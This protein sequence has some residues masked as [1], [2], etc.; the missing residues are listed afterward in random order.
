[1]SEAVFRIGAGQGAVDVGISAQLFLIA[2]PCVIESEGHCV[3]IAERL[4]DIGRR[5]GVGVLFKASFDKAN[6]SSIS[7]FRG[8]GLEA[9][10]EILAR[11]REKSGLPVVTDVH[12][13]AQAEAVAKVADCLQVPAF[14]CRQT[15]LLCACARTAKPVNVKKGQFVSPA[16]M[17]NVV[18]KINACGNEKILLTERGTFFGYNRLVNDMTA[19]EGMKQLGY[20]VVFDATHSTQCPGGLGNASAGNPEMS[21][22][23][24]KAAIAAGANGL[25]L[26]VHTD[27]KK[28]KSDA[29]CVVP[30]E[31]VEPLLRVSR[32]IFEIVR[33]S[34]GE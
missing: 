33:N 30:M 19:I 23:L 15:D 25:F 21:P 24:A 14:L 29:A 17:K 32:S 20:P 5:V 8:P 28:A 7:S 27:P 9:G 2:G 16:E 31:W 13:A 11:V 1:M 10:L 26:E 3:E 12:E 18:D 4:R 6:R 34:D 22:V